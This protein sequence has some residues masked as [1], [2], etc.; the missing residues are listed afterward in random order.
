MLYASQTILKSHPY[1]MMKLTIKQ[2][3]AFADDFLKHYLSNGYGT[4]GK[5]EIDI[6]V[7]HLI[8]EALGIKGTNPTMSSQ[9]LPDGSPNH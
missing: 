1:T 6:M 2:K 3:E 9:T 5:A 4:M 8:S 7:F